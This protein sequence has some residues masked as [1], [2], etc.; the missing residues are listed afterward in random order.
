MIKYT[1]DNM[2]DTLIK[3]FPEFYP[4]WKEYQ[5]EV[6]GYD[7]RELGLNIVAFN[8]Y[9]MDTL[10]KRDYSLI[11]R[12]MNLV[13]EFLKYG[14]ENVV[15]QT[16]I[17]IIEGVIIGEPREI[18][19]NIYYKYTGPRTREVIRELDRG[20]GTRTPY[21]W[22]DEEIEEFNRNKNQKK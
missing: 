8:H 21:F 20:W 10:N 9:F 1:K 6:I 16:H 2:V 22:S 12:I 4:L 13:E 19:P 18:D 3:N 5:E 11:K 17:G 14:D 15:Y 7:K